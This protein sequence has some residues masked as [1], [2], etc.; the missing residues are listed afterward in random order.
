MTGGTETWLTTWNHLDGSTCDAGFQAPTPRAKDGSHWWCVVHQQHLERA[1][2]HPI[3][4]GSA[5]V[6]E[7]GG[8]L[9]RVLDAIVL[10]PH[11]LLVLTLPWDTD[12]E[13][14]QQCQDIINDRPEFRD[15]VLL[16]SEALRPAADLD[17]RPTGRHAR[18]D[19]KEG[20]Q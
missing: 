17:F 11:D 12:P 3:L 6:E 19:D 4:D 1:D 18:P 8:D 15:R 7:V 9:V 13:E 14:A 5:L 2:S 16:V 20:S 10:G